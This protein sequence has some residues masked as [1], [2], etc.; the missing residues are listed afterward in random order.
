VPVIALDHLALPTNDGARLAAFYG[1]LGFALHGFDEWRA[2]QAPMFSILCGD[3][4][5]HVHPENLVRARGHPAY[6]RGD[7][8]EAGCG[9]VCVVW[10]GGVATLLA[11]LARE[12]V[13]PI[14]GPVPRLGGRAGATTVGISVYVRD[15]DHNLLEFISYDPGD[16]TAHRDARP[17]R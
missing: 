13:E 2:G 10:G 3:Q 8:A 5:I 9:D 12:G 4:K 7:A 15:P 17:V 11:L 14:D 16:L 6:L 1:A